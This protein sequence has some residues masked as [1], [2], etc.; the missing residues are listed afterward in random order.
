MSG[1]G[2][3]NRRNRRDRCDGGKR[4]E[5]SKNCVP[6]TCILLANHDVREAVHNLHSYKEDASFKSS[7][8]EQ[9]KDEPG[10]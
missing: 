1:S 4:N 7:D 3:R 2:L 8:N 5:H 6:N 9:L 10:G